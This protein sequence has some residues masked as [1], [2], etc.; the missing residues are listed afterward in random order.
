MELQPQKELRLWVPPHI[1][2]EEIVEKANEW[3]VQNPETPPLARLIQDY[4]SS[5]W[6]LMWHLQT[7]TTFLLT[8]RM[9]SV[10]DSCTPDESI[11]PICHN[12][13]AGGQELLECRHSFHTMCIHRWLRCANTCPVCR[14]EV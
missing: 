8:S 12:V 1:S 6:P 5:A 10:V 7:Q 11:C 4:V 14:T 3:L 2:A 9:V 13:L